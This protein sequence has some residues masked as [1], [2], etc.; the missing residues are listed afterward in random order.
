MYALAMYPGDEAFLEN[1]KQ[2][3]VDQRMRLRHHPSIV[4]WCGNNESS[5][6]WHRWGWQDGKTE[7]QK[8]KM[9]SD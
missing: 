7:K 2:E 6:G 8:D 3:A 9:W 4:L 1:A 5:E